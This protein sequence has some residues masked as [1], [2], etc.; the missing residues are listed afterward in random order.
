MNAKQAIRK[1]YNGE[2]NFMTPNVIEYME[3][4]T[5]R[6]ELS[7]GTGIFSDRMYGVTVVTPEG[8]R[9]E[10]GSCFPTEQEARSYINGLP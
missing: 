10:H 3:T 2:P 7:W 5:L 4:D 8:E 6:I 1:C 9:T